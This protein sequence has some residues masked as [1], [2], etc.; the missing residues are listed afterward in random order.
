MDDNMADDTLPPGEDGGMYDVSNNVTNIYYDSGYIVCY[1]PSYDFMRS[2]SRHP[3]RPPFTLARN[4][5]RADGNNSATISGNTLQVTAPHIFRNRNPETPKNLRGHIA[6]PR[7]VSSSAPPPAPGASNAPATVSTINPPTGMRIPSQ[8]KPVPLTPDVTAQKAHDFNLI[9]QE[10][11]ARVA[12][13]HST[14]NLPTKGALQSPPTPKPIRMSEP[15]PVIPRD[16]IVRPPQPVVV[17]SFS[18]APGRP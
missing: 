10:Q 6:D 4:G 16:Q 2:K 15:P 18:P 8:M 7:V 5:Y 11:T 9:R 13:E 12:E 17:P 3:F 1:G 14:E